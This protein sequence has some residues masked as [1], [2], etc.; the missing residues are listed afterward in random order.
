MEVATKPCEV[1][2]RLQAVMPGQDIV[3]TLRLELRLLELG[4][5]RAPT[6]GRPL[7]IFQDS[8]ICPRG[9]AEICPNCTLMQFVPLKCRSEAAPCQHIRLNDACE[10]IDSLYRTGTQ[11]EVEE[12]LVK[13]LRATIQ[14]IVEKQSA[15]EGSG[16]TEFSDGDGKASMGEGGNYDSSC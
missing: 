10:T 16:T 3:E 4:I 1:E 7:L 11:A 12:E 5:Y 15:G 14:R 9:D 6:A 2:S 13:W 8:P